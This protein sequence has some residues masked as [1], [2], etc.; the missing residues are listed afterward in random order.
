MTLRRIVT[1]V[2]LAMMVS[3]LPAHADVGPWVTQGSD[4]ARPDTESQGLTTVIRP[5]SSFIRY[6][7]FGTIPSGVRNRGWN[8]VGD[9]GSRRGYYIE[10]YQSDTIRGKMFRVENPSGGWSEYTH[11]LESWEAHNNSFTAVSPSGNWMVSGEWGNMN[12]L[13]VFP[14]PGIAFTNPGANLPYS[15][16]IRLNRTVTDIQGCEFFSDTRLLCSSN[17]S[18]KPLIQVDIAA[19]LSGSDVAGIVTTLGSLPQQSG[20]SGNFETEG[21]DYDTRD[22]TL[23]VVMISPGICAA[24]DSKTWRFKH[25]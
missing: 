19:P 23:R 2:A 16:A 1:A 25:R 24:F 21:I 11:Q 8:H 9:P 5:N 20:C 7:G 15:S 6:T 4:R 13:L 10:P 17:G 14:T 3:A 18:G 22:G 12:R